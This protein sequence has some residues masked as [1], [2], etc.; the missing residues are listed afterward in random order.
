[1]AVC[2]YCDQEMLWADG[3]VADPI[4]IGGRSYQPVRYGSELHY[5]RPNRRCHDCRALPGGIHHHGCD[6]EECPACGGQSISCGC[7][8][9]GEE[10][11]AEDWVDEME[12]RFQLVG[13]DE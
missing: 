3:C 13:P 10:H 6:M 1:M 8:W 9:A 4:A 12:E 5:G 11:L 7:L 2:S